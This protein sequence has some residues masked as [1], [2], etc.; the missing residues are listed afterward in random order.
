M[1]SNVTFVRGKDLAAK[2]V[3]EHAQHRLTAVLKLSLKLRRLWWER[4]AQHQMVARLQSWSANVPKVV[5]PIVA[6][7]TSAMHLRES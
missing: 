2:A 7:L 4:H 6:R 5:K 1:Q 3:M